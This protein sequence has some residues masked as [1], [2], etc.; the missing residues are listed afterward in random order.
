VPG[1]DHSHSY[2]INGNPKGTKNFFNRRP[3]GKIHYLLPKPVVSEIGKEF[4][5]QSH[6]MGPL[7]VPEGINGFIAYIPDDIMRW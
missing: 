2:F 3:L 6:L 4:N 7:K 1:V 5:I